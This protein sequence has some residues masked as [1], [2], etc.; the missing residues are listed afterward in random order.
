MRAAPEVQVVGGPVDNNGGPCGPAS[1]AKT[2]VMTR[3]SAGT[4]VH[5][6]PIERA[7]LPI[8]G[9]SPA[10]A[11]LEYAERR[12]PRSSSQDPRGGGDK[13]S[14]QVSEER[15]D[16]GEAIDVSRTWWNLACVGCFTAL[17][18][19][20]SLLPGIYHGASYRLPYDV[21][22]NSGPARAILAGHY[23]SMYKVSGGFDALPIAPLLLVPVVALSDL[24]HLT[25]SRTGASLWLLL[26][27]VTSFLCSLVAPAARSLAWAVGR[28][29]NLWMLQ[30]T[31]LL[32]CALPCALWGHFEDALAL[33]CLMYAWRAASRARWDAAAL[34]C[35]VAVASKEWAVL[36]VPFLVVMAPAGRRV[37]ALL[38]CALLPAVLVAPCLVADFRSTVL[39]IFDSAGRAKLGWDYLGRVAGTVGRTTVL[40]AAPATA[41]VLGRKRLGSTL[42]VIAF[43]FAMRVILEPYVFTYYVVAP[44]GTLIIAVVVKE[45]RITA[46]DQ[47]FLVLPMLWVIPEMTRSGAWYLGWAITWVMATAPLWRRRLPGSPHRLAVAELEVVEDTMIA[48]PGTSAQPLARTG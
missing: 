44:L 41:L 42:S 27:P 10:L 45:G 21:W 22:L 16:Q 23:G 5:G 47:V 31:V 40:I 3:R 1:A 28:R 24:L 46:R 11:R 34:W 26:C 2:T 29:T 33:A 14:S 8:Y 13:T 35:S 32:A 7:R 25:E 36:A 4:L 48:G 20:W 39:G 17:F 15:A 9:A 6:S 19:L 12:G 18:T 37:K 43:L 30:A 38:L